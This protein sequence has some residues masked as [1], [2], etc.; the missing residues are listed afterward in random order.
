MVFG[1]FTFYVSFRM[2]LGCTELID[3]RGATARISYI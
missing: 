1:Y 3:A 2:V